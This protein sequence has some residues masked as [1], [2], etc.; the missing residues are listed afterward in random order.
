MIA[1]NKISDNTCIVPTDIKYNAPCK[2]A[3][4]SKDGPVSLTRMSFPAGE[5]RTPSNL[6]ERDIRKIKVKEVFPELSVR[7]KKLIK[8]F[9][10]DID[11]NNNESILPWITGRVWAD[12]YKSN[13]HIRL[14]TIYKHDTIAG[15][16]GN[17]DLQL[18][19]F[20]LFN[21]F[22]IDYSVLACI[23]WM[24]NPP[25][26]SVHEIFVAAV[27]YGFNYNVTESEYIQLDELITSVNNLITTEPYYRSESR[28]KF[29]RSNL[30]A[31]NFICKIKSLSKEKEMAL[32]EQV[33]V[34]KKCRV[35]FPEKEIGCDSFDKRKIY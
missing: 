35:V 27:P 28:N 21:D 30:I 18:D 19:I 15:P 31:S 8:D 16:S 23:I 34:Q 26:H 32:T 3:S 2:L 10:K 13:L 5:L 14:A 6:S 1:C 25:D 17:T 24:C 7:E 20:Q 4:F 11:F 12:P 33:N 9:N 29:K 22:D